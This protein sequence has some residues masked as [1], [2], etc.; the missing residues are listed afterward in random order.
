[1]NLQGRTVLVTGGVSG[2]GGAVADMIV[3]AGG[4]AVMLDVNDEKGRAKV[5]QLGNAVRFVKGDVT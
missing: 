5:S 3:A 4:R 2:L 1:V